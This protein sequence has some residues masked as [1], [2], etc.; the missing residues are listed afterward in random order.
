MLFSLVNRGQN[1]SEALQVIE[2]YDGTLYEFTQWLSKIEKDLNYLEDYCTK[3]DEHDSTK[4]TVI[5]LYKVSYSINNYKIIYS[6]KT[7]FIF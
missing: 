4:Q 6:L 1:I 2:E 5:E 7:V 3:S